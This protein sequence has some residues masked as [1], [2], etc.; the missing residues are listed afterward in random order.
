M[1]KKLTKPHKKKTVPGTTLLEDGTLDRIMRP[2]WNKDTLRKAVA[3]FGK[4]QGPSPLGQELGREKI[5]AG[6]ARRYPHDLLMRRPVTVGY[7]PGKN[8]RCS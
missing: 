8:T 1:K 6:L 4:Y 2:P 3:A 5:R 7:S